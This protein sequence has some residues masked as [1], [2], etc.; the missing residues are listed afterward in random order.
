MGGGGCG[1]GKSGKVEGFHGIVV[2]GSG[3]TNVL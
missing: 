2:K 3:M 1:G